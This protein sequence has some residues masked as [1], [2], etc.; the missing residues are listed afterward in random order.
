M[1]ILMTN[2]KQHI[3]ASFIAPALFLASGIAAWGSERTDIPVPKN[4]I[5]AGQTLV[6]ELLRSRSVPRDYTTRVSI[7]KDSRQLV[8]K[9]ARKTLLPNRPIFTNTVVEPDVVEVNRKTL[10]RYDAGGLKISAEVSPLN[11][12]K[13]GEPV[14]ARNIRTGIVVY[15]TANAD[16]TIQVSSIR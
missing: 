2:I 1:K 14:R 15:G 10:M 13:A 11:S 12:A 4:I 5:Y 8:G 3:I 16:G 6:P 7:Y 9:V